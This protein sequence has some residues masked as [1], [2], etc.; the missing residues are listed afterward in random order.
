AAADVRRKGAAPLA[1][2]GPMTA[3]S[4]PAQDDRRGAG[5]PIDLIRQISKP[6]DRAQV[7]T[8]VRDDSDPFHDGT[9]M[10][11]QRHACIPPALL[12][13]ADDITRVSEKSCI[14]Y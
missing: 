11:V 12:C 7:E 3:V 4:V 9:Q 6:L 13:R 1:V 10:P 2:V 8:I 5:Y 14:S